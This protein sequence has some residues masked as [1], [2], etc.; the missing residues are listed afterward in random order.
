VCRT[1]R[2]ACLVVDIAPLIIDIIIVTALTALLYVIC[3]WRNIVA[4][5]NHRNLQ[6]LRKL[7]FCYSCGEAFTPEDVRTRDH[8]P[9]TSLF[10]D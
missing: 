9:P 1:C 8:V 10:R 6:N 2:F 3:R 4:I 5:V 7:P